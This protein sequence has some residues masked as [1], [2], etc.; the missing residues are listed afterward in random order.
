M[1][2][3]VQEPIYDRCIKIVCDSYYSQCQFCNMG[4]SQSKRRGG[5][6]QQQQQSPNGSM[7]IS[8]NENDAEDAIARLPV[9]VVVYMFGFL[10]LRSVLNVLRSCKKMHALGQTSLRIWKDRSLRLLVPQS[11]VPITTTPFNCANT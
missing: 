9:D 1:L 10:D 8:E 11:S 5:S 4:S 3:Q 6:H 7:S 2:F